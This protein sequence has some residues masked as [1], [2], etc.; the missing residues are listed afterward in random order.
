[1]VP[2]T[3][4]SQPLKRHLDRF[5][6]FCTAHPCAQHT[7]RQQTTLRAT[8]VAVGHIYALR[9]DDAA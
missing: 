1:M 8:S 4:V 3:D 9:A 2:W 7:H 6:R 5:S